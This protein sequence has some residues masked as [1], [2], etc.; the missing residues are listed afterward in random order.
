MRGTRSRWIF[1]PAPASPEPSRFLTHSGRK[2]AGTPSGIIGAGSTLEISS[3]V[4]GHQRY[5]GIQ[6]PG[7]WMVSSLVGPG[8]AARAR[9]GASGFSPKRSRS[10]SCPAPRLARSSARRVV[11]VMA[12]T[13]S[14][15]QRERIADER[16]ADRRPRRGGPLGLVDEEHAL[17]EIVDLAIRGGLA[18]QAQLEIRDVRANRLL[19][20]GAGLRERRVSED[21]L[22]AR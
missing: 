22:V 9:A 4:S 11:L 18:D 21:G 2:Y 15:G 10:A 14:V 12:G 20:V 17:E 13:S 6:P 7:T 5:A 1:S 19:A 3:A 8:E 16:C